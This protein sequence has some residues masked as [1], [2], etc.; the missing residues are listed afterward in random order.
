VIIDDLLKELG[1]LASGRVPVETA[2][3]EPAHMSHVIS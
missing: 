1:H 2:F 3:I